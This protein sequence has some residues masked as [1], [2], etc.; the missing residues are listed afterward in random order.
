M[1]FAVFLFKRNAN[2]QMQPKLQH[3]RFRLFVVQP[4]VCV[5][6]VSIHVYICMYVYAM[7]LCS[8]STMSHVPHVLV[9]RISIFVVCNLPFDWTKKINALVF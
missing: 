9:F 7:P 5:I 6:C 3:F 2:N 1:L 4:R 8:L